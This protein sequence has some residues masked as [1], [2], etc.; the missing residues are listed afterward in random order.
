[1]LFHK[2]TLLKIYFGVLVILQRYRIVYKKC[3]AITVR[4]KIDHD[5]ISASSLSS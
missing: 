3:A 4:K 2:N 1:M 5:I